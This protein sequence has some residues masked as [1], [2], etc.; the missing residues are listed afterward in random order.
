MVTVVDIQKDLP[1]WPEGIIADWLLYFANEPDLK[2]PPPEPLGGHRWSLILGGRPLSWWKNVTW[3][4]QAVKCDLRSLCPPSRGRVEGTHQDAHGGLADDVEV[5]RY[6]MPMQYILEN[7]V[8]LKPI[9]GM[10]RPD[11][12]LVLDGHQRMPAHH[13]LQQMADAFF[14]KPN[15]KKAALEQ[16][17]WIGTHKGSELPLT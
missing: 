12:L 3:M 6:R 8:F 14:E 13:G 9:V 5:R 1:D 16:E 7:G 11:G 15:R 4:K 17:A 2:W 10:N